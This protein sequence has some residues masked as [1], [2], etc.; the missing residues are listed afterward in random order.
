MLVCKKSFY[1]HTDEVGIEKEYIFDKLNPLS[2]LLIDIAV[3]VWLAIYTAIYWG[4]F[5]LEFG[6][7]RTPSPSF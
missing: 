4:L 5:I 1:H 3:I 6:H 2:W 7:F